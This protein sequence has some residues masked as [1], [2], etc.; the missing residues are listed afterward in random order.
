MIEPQQWRGE[1]LDLPAEVR[2]AAESAFA[3]ETGSVLSAETASEL[4]ALDFGQGLI[5]ELSALSAPETPR[6]EE[7]V[8]AAS[9][10]IGPESQAAL[11]RWREKEMA[12]RKASQKIFQTMS[13]KEDVDK[14]AQEAQEKQ[15]RAI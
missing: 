4:I 15:E 3:A 7:A 14:Q 1:D 9:G 6:D 2:V 13:W 5:G 11:A 8:G 12:D 10:T